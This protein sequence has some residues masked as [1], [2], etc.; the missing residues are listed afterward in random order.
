METGSIKII[1][2]EGKAPSVEAQ[3]VNNN[4]WLSAWEIA[5]LF[6]VFNQKIEMNLRSIFKSHLLWEEDVSF[7]YRYTDKGIEKQ[8]VYYN[9]EV[10]IFL[11][12]RIATPEAQIF[13]QFVKAALC[14]RLK[15]DKTP[16]QGSVQIVWLYNY[17]INCLRN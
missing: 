17:Q 5:R 12:Y 16:K 6:N 7:T 4:L 3:L 13:R 8:N 9:F 2:E 11:S 1:I 10:L 14:E 15:K